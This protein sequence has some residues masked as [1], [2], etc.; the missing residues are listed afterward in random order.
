MTLLFAANLINALFFQIPLA[1]CSEGNF[2]SPIICPN[3]ASGLGAARLER[4][5]RIAF[6]GA[7]RYNSGSQVVKSGEKFHV[8]VQKW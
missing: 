3:K 8:V 6:R 7:V 2:R 5:F 4:I 1:I